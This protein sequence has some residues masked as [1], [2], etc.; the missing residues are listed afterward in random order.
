MPTLKKIAEQICRKNLP[1]LLPDTCS[2]LDIIRDVA[3]K[4][5]VKDVL[6]GLSVGK[7]CANPNPKCSVAV[8]SVI[9]KEYADHFEQAQGTVSTT[10]GSLYKY[11]A[12]INKIRVAQGFDELQADQ[13]TSTIPYLTSVVES[14]LDSS[15]EIQENPEQILKAHHRVVAKSPPSGGKNSYKDCLIWEEYLALAECIRKAGGSMP[16]AFVS[17]NKSDFVMNHPTLKTLDTEAA[18]FDIALC[19]NWEKIH[20]ELGL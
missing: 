11:I 18:R 1:L 5:E 20:H 4:D 17:S 10:F 7:A 3:R 12:R 13:D 2:L 6:F 9:P 16:I 15:W 14:L 8:A 19:P